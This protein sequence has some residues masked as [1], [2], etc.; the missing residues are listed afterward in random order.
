MRSAEAME[1][2]RAWLQSTDHLI[3]RDHHHDAQGQHPVGGG[4]E[5]YVVRIASRVSEHDVRM[6]VGIQV[7]DTRDGVVLD[8]VSHGGHTLI[9][10]VMPTAP[11][12]GFSGLTIAIDVH[13]C[14]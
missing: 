3:R 9:C 8:V 14:Q 2:V 13:I 1:R 4:V 5:H 6:D 12:V 11:V 10:R 7:R